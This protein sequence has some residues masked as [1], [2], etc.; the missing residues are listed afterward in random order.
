VLE[1][2][3][4]PAATMVA[5]VQERTGVVICRSTMRNILTAG[6][7]CW[8]PQKKC[9]RLSD[10]QIQARQQFVLDWNGSRYERSAADPWYSRINLVS[11]R[12]RTAVGSGGEEESIQ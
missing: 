8:G 5:M 12:D 1:N 10:L 6:H 2:G 3:G 4:F 11:A 7:F 9:P